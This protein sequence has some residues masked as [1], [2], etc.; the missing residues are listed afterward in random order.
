M[1]TEAHVTF[2]AGSRNA[3]RWSSCDPGRD[4]ETPRDADP[5]VDRPKCPETDDAGAMIRN[6]VGLE[7]QDAPF[8]DREWRP[9][10]DTIVSTAM[11]AELIAGRPSITP[12]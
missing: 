12:L 10:A 5:D 3:Q 11:L 2:A 9:I 6:R 1:R 4:A 7:F 8:T